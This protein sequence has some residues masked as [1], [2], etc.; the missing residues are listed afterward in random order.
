M[1][2]RYQ[3]ALRP[4]SGGLAAVGISNVSSVRPACQAFR[5]EPTIFILTMTSQ[6]HQIR[7]PNTLVRKRASQ[8]DAH[9]DFTYG[10][11]HGLKI[12]GAAMPGQVILARELRLGVIESGSRYLARRFGLA[13]SAKTSCAL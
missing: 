6:G 4:E 1:Q 7:R 11:W 13:E 8:F 5:S 2:V 9:S 3:A 12:G 10:F